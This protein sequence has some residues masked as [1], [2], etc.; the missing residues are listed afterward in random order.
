M[1]WF[2]QMDDIVYLQPNEVKLLIDTIDNIEDKALI[3]TG[4]ETGMR[5]SETTKGFKVEMI[6]FA[7]GTAK[8]WDEKKDIYR[9]IAIPTNALNLLRMYLNTK[10]R[11]KGDVFPFSY[12]TANRKLMY[13]VKKAGI[14]KY[15][16]G[17]PTN[18]TWHKLRHS[19]VRLSAQAHRD[20]QAVA[21]QIG[22]R[23]TTVL[24]IY[25]TWE[26]SAMSKH[27]DEKPL[28]KGD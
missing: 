11:K 26:T 17:K 7:D 20:P 8:I 1:R 5:V 10:K 13:W 18:F 19:F 22:D 16:N 14:R 23:L 25:G 3:V 6:N 21:Q 9:D 4:I 28:I 2:R 27:F 24:R 15:A 12:K